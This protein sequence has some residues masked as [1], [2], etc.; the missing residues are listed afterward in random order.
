MTSL[1]TDVTGNQLETDPLLGSLANNG[2]TGGMATR[3]PLAGSPAI[4][5]GDPA[6]SGPTLDERGTGFARI[7]G[8]RVDIGAVEVTPQLAPTGSVVSWWLLLLAGGAFIVGFAVL[9][10]TRRRDA[11]T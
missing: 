11:L 10:I 4:D 9:L 8:G 2:G 5:L 7:L 3:L 6:Y 1:A